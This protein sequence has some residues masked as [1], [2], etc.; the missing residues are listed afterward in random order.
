MALIGS[1]HLV[2]SSDGSTSVSASAEG[3]LGRLEG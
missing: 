3:Q 1:D 2:R